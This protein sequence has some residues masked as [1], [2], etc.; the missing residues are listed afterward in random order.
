MITPKSPTS[1]FCI[2]EKRALFKIKYINE[3]VVRISQKGRKLLGLIFDPHNIQCFFNFEIH[4]ALKSDLKKYG[5]LTIFLPLTFLKQNNLRDGNLIEIL[6]VKNTYYFISIVSQRLKDYFFEF[7]QSSNSNSY[8]ILI[9]SSHGRADLDTATIADNIFQDLKNKK[10][11]CL[12]LQPRFRFL[13]QRGNNE[14]LLK[15]G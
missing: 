8:T 1:R 11:S 3:N 2:P 6:K 13:K 12:R 10:I 14:I 15:D 7:N 5:E 4:Q 9:L